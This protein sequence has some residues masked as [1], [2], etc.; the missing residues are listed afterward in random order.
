MRVFVSGVGDLANTKVV[1]FE[2]DGF[3]WK[4][5]VPYD[6]PE[7]M[8]AAGVVLGPPNLSVLSLPVDIERKINNELFARG[9]ITKGDVRMRSADVLGAITSALKLD[10]NKIMDQYT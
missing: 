5:M 7:E 9:L 1:D 3:K 2:R 6:A 8:Y 10:A 4:V